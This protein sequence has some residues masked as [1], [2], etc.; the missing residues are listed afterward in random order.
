MNKLSIRD[1]CKISTN[2]DNDTFVG[3]ICENGDFSVHFPMGFHVSEDDKELRKDILLLMNTISMTTNR[4]DSEIQGK[5]Y[6]FNDL[7]FPFQAYLDVVYDYYSRGYYKEQEVEYSVSKRGKIDWNRTI[8][9]QKAYVQNTDVFYLDFVTKKSMVKENELITLIH[10]YCVYDAFI[11]I[12]WIFTESLPQ[13]PS[14]KYNQKLFRGIV[15]DKLQHT[16]NDRN[17]ILLNSMLEI[18]EYLGNNGSNINYKYGTYRF[19]YVW[20]ALIDRVFGIYEKEIYYP[21]TTWNLGSAQYQVDE[22]YDNSSLR[23]DTI[24]LYNGDIYVLDAKYYKYGIYGNPAFLPKSTDINKQITYGEYIAGQDKFKSL[25]GSDYKVYNA[26]LMPF[27]SLSKYW[28]SSNKII[29]VGHASGN[30]KNNLKEYETVQGIL[31]D[32]KYMM[33]VKICHDEEKIKLLSKII[34]TECR[35]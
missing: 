12:G 6:E 16:F 30:W 26:F 19:E 5:S 29:G 18:I 32:L 33:K 1:R 24:M 22:K 20:E 13:K 28:N 11:N 2:V 10:E 17:R 8:K 7:G 21:S 31:I 23:P 25:H 3:I 34:E 35:R 15:H 9:T 4:K 14:I 27:D